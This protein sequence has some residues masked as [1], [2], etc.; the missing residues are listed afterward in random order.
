M[1]NVVIA[2]LAKKEHAVAVIFLLNEYARDIMGGGKDLSA[3]TKKHLIEELVNRPNCHV[4]LAWVDEQPAGVSI[5][6]ESF[7]T[8]ACKPILNI[9][10]LAVALQY[11][12]QGI[13]RD[14][15]FKIEELAQKLG[16]CKLT[17]EVLE[18][19]KR[20]QHVYE[21]F[22]FASYELDPG[23]GR[24]LFLEKKF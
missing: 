24:A 9:H 12:G 2:D 23:T 8:F 4:F 20:A 5:C 21:K 7:S 16:C 22:G 1:I 11:R 19:N 15:L 10:D 18:G 3:F 6:F 17:L 14:I 13:S